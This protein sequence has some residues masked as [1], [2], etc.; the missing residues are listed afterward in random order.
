[1][2]KL[3]LDDLSDNDIINGLTLLSVAGVILFFSACNLK[4]TSSNTKQAKV[5][6]EK[7]SYEPHSRK[8]NGDLDETPNLSYH[9]NYKQNYPAK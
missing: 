3:R 5:I 2:K 9:M 4:D 7:T 8:L 1:M 6:A